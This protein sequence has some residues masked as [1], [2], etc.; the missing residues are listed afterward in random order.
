MV[1]AINAP[2]PSPRTMTARGRRQQ[3]DAANAPTRLMTAGFRSFE[4]HHASSLLRTTAEPLWVLKARARD[5]LQGFCHNGIDMG[6]VAKIL[7]PGAKVKPHSCLVDDLADATT[8][9]MTE[10]FAA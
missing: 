9:A 2:L 3:R 8:A 6:E 1:V 5:Q 4:A 10:A 7:E